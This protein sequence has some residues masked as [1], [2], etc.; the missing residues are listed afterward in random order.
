MW[1]RRGA[2]RTHR[3]YS[4]AGVRAQRRQLRCRGWRRSGTGEGS[5]CDIYIDN[6]GMISSRNDNYA[7]N[8]REKAIM[9]RNKLVPVQLLKPYYKFFIGDRYR[10]LKNQIKHNMSYFVENQELGSGDAGGSKIFLG[11][12]V[13]RIFF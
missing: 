5:N 6:Q 13:V 10:E 4:D 9:L 11:D 1:A 7:K 12:S 8:T 2:P 3:S